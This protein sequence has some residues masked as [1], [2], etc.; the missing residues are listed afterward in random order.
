MLNSSNKDIKALVARLSEAGVLSHPGL[1][2]HVKRALATG[3]YSLLA[4]FLQNYPYILATAE[5]NLELEKHQSAINPFMPYPTRLE[6]SKFLQG[7][8]HLGYVN[9]FN[10]R[11]SIDYDVFSK[12]IMNMGRVGSGKSIFIKR[13]LCQTLRKKRDFNVLIP[14]LKREYRH[15]CLT[16]KDLKV[17]KVDMIKINP[18]QVPYWASPLDHA[19]TF[20]R[21]FVS[22]NWLVGTSENLLIDLVYQLYKE[23]GVLDGSINYPT[24]HDLYALITK[25]LSGTKSFRYSDLLLWLQNRIRPY[26]IH[27]SFNCKFGIPFDVFRK[28]NLVLEMDEGFT[29]M[30][31]NFTV[32][33]IVHQLYQYNKKKNL[34]GSKLR[35]WIVVD[36][37]RILFNASRDTSTFGESILNE[38]VSKSREFGIGFFLTSQEA[39]S[40]NQLFR[41]LAYLKIAFPINDAADL[42]FIQESFGLNDE[43]TRHLFRLPPY[44]V[45]VV[46]YGGFEK[47]FLLGVPKF[48]IKHQIDDDQLRIK[49]E[50][51]WVTLQSDLEESTIGAIISKSQTIESKLPANSAALLFF[52]GKN[53]FTKYSDLIN[54]PGFNSSRDVNKAIK[55]LVE[56]GFVVNEKYRT[57]RGRKSHYSVL[58]DKALKYLK[59]DGIP[60][61]GSFEHSLYQHLVVNWLTARGDQAKIEGT[62]ERS[63]KSIDV[64]AH[65][66]KTGHA[67]YEVTLHFGNLIENINQDL[68][69][70]ANEVIVVTR[71]K[72]SFA[73]AKKIVGSEFQGKNDI[74]R[75]AFKTIDDFFG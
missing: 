40:F 71:D 68:R 18:L 72:K 62:I 38:I 75:V 8:L 48:N 73:I 33:T 5:K 35:N 23:N 10:S 26:L 30:M 20:A 16:C 69:A 11:F 54:V 36:E 14:D 52:L 43:Q 60:G 65:S 34:T 74:A 53:P 56:N 63:S 2:I 49:M 15:L 70:G 28:E 67:A 61:K 42:K 25:R 44:G 1:A 22:E 45:A 32:A 17:L 58:Q 57:S 9:E 7:P 27:D 31:Y 24:L 19:M 29:D 39:S 3:D 64:L 66:E 51:F 4:G 6:A 50:G 12:P 41:A 46:R 21:V 13:L 55:W 37:A 59:I 47:P